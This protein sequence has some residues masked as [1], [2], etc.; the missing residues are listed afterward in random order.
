MGRRYPSVG[1]K[2][3]GYGA[4]FRYRYPSVGLKVS[5]YGEKVPIYG[6]SHFRFKVATYGESKV[7]IY[8]ENS[9]FYLIHKDIDP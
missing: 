8:G 7:P 1:L 5:G 6:E 3:S 2:V 4:L 9:C